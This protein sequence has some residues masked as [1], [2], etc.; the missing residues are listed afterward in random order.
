LVKHPELMRL[1]REV[2]QALGLVGPVKLDFKR[3]PLDERLYL[4]EVNPRF[5]LWC[6]LGAVCGVNLPKIAYS[7]LVGETCELPSDYR[8]GV[9]WLSF[10]N[11][12]RAFVRDYGPRG[13]LSLVDW[14]LSYR[15]QKI[16]DIFS[17]RD[18]LP[19]GMCMLNYS[20]ALLER[21]APAR[22]LA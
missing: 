21:L 13:G 22:R 17:W 6:Y 19:L 3:D 11:D 5:T 7:D 18:P 12:F 10:G 14:I 16:Y 2:S 1:G 4:F 8:T 20:R 15:G 9:R